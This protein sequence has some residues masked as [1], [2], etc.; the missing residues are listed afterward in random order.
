MIGAGYH[1]KYLNFL[2]KRIKIVEKIKDSEITNRANTDP[3]KS[4]VLKAA[5]AKGCTKYIPE[6]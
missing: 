6:E 2:F 1:K 3:F 5:I 4:Y